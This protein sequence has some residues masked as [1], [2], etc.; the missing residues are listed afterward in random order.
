MDYF[1]RF[2]RSALHQ[3]L[4]RINTYPMR[5]ARKK[6][7]RPRSFKRFRAW[8]TGVL[9]E[10]FARGEIDE[11]EYSRRLHVLPGAALTHPSGG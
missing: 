4:Q 2:Y 6:Y 7:R 3:L 10:R 8:W 9:A 11:E 1:G 5:W